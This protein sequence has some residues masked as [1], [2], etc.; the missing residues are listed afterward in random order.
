MLAGMPRDVRVVIVDDHPAFADSLAYRLNA[1]PDVQ[2]VETVRTS[3]VGIAS[4]DLRHPDIAIVDIELGGENGLTLIREVHSHSPN[5][6]VVVVTAHDDPETAIRAARAGAAAFI[7]KD[8]PSEQLV[9]VIRG[10]MT[11]ESH[12]PPKLLTQ[13]LEHFTSG[14]DQADESRERL[15]ALSDRELEVLRLLVDG[16]DRTSIAERLY[17]SVNTVRTHTKNI[18]AKLEVHSSLEAVS[19][20]L[21]AGIRPHDLEHD[22]EGTGPGSRR[23]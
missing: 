13:I 20:A 15:A 18:F 21:Q 9:S 14:E 5:T 17:L 22:N 4:I 12:Y 1:E 8:S 10:V 11:G 23:G 3:D 19:L 7:P 16:L 2:V 6:R